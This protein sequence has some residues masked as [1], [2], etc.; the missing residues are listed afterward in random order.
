LRDCAAIRGSRK[1]QTIREG[2]EVTQS[3]Q[4][5]VCPSLTRA[6]LMPPPSALAG[7]DV[8]DISMSHVDALV[9]RAPHCADAGSHASRAKD[10]RPDRC[11][12]QTWS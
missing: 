6:R 1:A 12:G 4:I 3:A 7:A 11:N 10:C 2:N 8:P 5:H 9:R